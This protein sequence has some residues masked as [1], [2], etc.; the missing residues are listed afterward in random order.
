MTSTPRRPT[1][2]IAAAVLRVAGAVVIRLVATLLHPIAG[3]RAMTTNWRY[4]VLCMDLRTPPELVPNTGGLGVQATMIAALLALHLILPS[5]V[6]AVVAVFWLLHHLFT[7]VPISFV[8]QL[9]VGAVVGL[10][11]GTCVLG[12]YYLLGRTLAPTIV[13]WAALLFRFS[14][15]STA[16]VW[17]P[18][19]LVGPAAAER[20]LPIDIYLEYLRESGPAKL[21]RVVAWFLALTLALTIGERLELLRYAALR[22]LVD[23]MRNLPEQLFPWQLTAGLVWWCSSATTSSQDAIDTSSTPACGRSRALRRSPTAARRRYGSSC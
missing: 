13:G 6:A 20:R 23:P 17:S 2:A 5:F 15:K 14:V 11:L 9:F 4:A 12:L 16:V 8:G 7:A 18:L 22:E 19:L 21:A 3:V 1:A 10:V